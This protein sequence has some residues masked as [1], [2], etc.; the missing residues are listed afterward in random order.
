MPIYEYACPECGARIDRLEKMIYRE[1][2][3]APPVLMCENGHD[4]AVMQKIIS[5]EGGFILKGRWYKTTKTY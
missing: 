3:E 1:G 2:D 4:E 5:A